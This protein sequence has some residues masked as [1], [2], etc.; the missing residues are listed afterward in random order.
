MALNFYTM[1]YELMCR[2]KTYG[3]DNAYSRLETLVNRFNIEH[4][5][6]GNLLY[7]GEK[8]STAAKAMLDSGGN[9][10][11]AASFRLLQRMALWEF[12][13]IKMDYTLLP[14]SHPLA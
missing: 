9:F 13:R 3:A 5:Q 14:T 10:R 6:G 12:M 8:I 7:Y 11:K 1:Y 2:L 4:L